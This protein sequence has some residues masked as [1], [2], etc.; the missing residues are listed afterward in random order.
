MRLV[1]RLGC[2]QAAEPSCPDRRYRREGSEGSS[3]AV[4]APCDYVDVFMTHD[5]ETAAGFRQ[6]SEPLA[7]ADRNLDSEGIGSI[8]K[9]RPRASWADVIATRLGRS[10]DPRGTPKKIHLGIKVE[11]KN[12]AV[13][14]TFLGTRGG[15]AAAAG[16][17]KP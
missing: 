1:R 10:V 5:I 17:M 13:D 9:N 4:L 15:I 6:S 16:W 7:R 12:T 14:L 3:Y 2:G 11:Q 8:Q